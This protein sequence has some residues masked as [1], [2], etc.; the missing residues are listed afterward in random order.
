MKLWAKWLVGDAE[1]GIAG[2]EKTDFRSTE[3]GVTEGERRRSLVQRSLLLGCICGKKRILSS[4]G[5]KID[6]PKQACSDLD[7]SCEF[8]HEFL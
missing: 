8:Q 1:K 6:L 7:N 2:H 3:T 4:P 5:S